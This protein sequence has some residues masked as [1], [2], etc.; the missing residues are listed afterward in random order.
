MFCG[1]ALWCV[2]VYVCGCACVQAGGA[3]V[4]VVGEDA[5]EYLGLFWYVHVPLGLLLG[6]CSTKVSKG[7]NYF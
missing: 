3:V 7:G 6:L 1:R 2:C 5:G 4:V